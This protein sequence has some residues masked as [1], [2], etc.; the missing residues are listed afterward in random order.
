MAQ[1]PRHLG[2]SFVSTGVRYTPQTLTAAQQ[3]Q[4]QANIG[5]AATAAVTVAL[6]QTNS[7]ITPAADATLTFS[8]ASGKVATITIVKGIV[9]AVTL[10]P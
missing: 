10:T 5:A 8:T 7:G 2:D 1:G 6:A 4:V 9:T 3:T